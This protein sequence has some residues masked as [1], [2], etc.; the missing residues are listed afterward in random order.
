[1]GHEIL[2]VKLYELDKKFARLHSRIQLSET[3]DL[4]QIEEELKAIQKECR[5]NKLALYNKMKFSRSKK[6]KQ[7]SEAYDKMEEIIEES[8]AQICGPLSDEEKEN[9]SAEEQILLAEYSLDFAIMAA[10]DA[11]QMSLEAIHSQ[12]SQEEGR[13]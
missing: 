11:L 12:K 3:A 6:V 2:S 9:L 5:E 1:M 8:R 13:K 4:E 10:D 7:L